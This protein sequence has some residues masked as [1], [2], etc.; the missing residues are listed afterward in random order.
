MLL[1]LAVSSVRV[2]ATG[3]LCHPVPQ[4]AGSGFATLTVHAAASLQL[5]C[6]HLLVLLLLL[7]LLLLVCLWRN[8][9]EAYYS[10]WQFWRFCFWPTVVFSTASF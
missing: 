4:Q 8:T 10:T 1:Y 2:P 7:L 6:L 5:P 9:V 3:Q